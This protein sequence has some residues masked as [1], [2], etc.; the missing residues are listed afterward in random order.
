MENDG[1]MDQTS[2]SRAFVYHRPGDVRTERRT[3]ALSSTDLLVKIRASA[4]CGTDRTI[5]AK[6]HPKVDANAPIVLGHE[7]TGEIVR[8][9]RDVRTLREGIGYR[10][11]QRLGD[12]ALDFREGERVTCQSRIARY[13]NGLMLLDRP[14]TILSFQID[15]AYAEYLRVPEELIRSGSVLRLPDSVGDEEGALVEPAACALES[16]FSTPHPV[17]VAADG[18]HRFASGPRRGGTAIVIGS[19]TVSL[20]Y[21]RL[22]RILGSARVFVLVR[23]ERKAAI[24][25]RVLGP[26]YTCVVAEPYDTLDLDERIRHEDEIVRRLGGLTGGALFDDVISASASPDAQRLMMRLYAASG[27]AVGACFGGTHALVDRADLDLNHYRAAKTI[28]TSGCSNRGMERIIEMLADG[29]L[30]LSGFTSTHRYTLDSD[31]ADFLTTE[32][33]GLKPVLSFDG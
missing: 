32:A 12:E 6:G 7:F 21:A 14:I 8:V 9:G 15:G 28:G 2:T 13:E 18:S 22:C 31:P 30:S 1:A 17:G 27:Y 19:G 5:F 25:R 20:I 24:A 11:G 33:D 23:S 29:T 16:I 10:A 3:I 4:R 26:G